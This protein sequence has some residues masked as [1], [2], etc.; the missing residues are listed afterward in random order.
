MS[1]AKFANHATD[2]DVV[3][4]MLFYAGP[5]LKYRFVQESV[6]GRRRNVADG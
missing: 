5:L 4:T 6:A 3:T 1:L 2:F